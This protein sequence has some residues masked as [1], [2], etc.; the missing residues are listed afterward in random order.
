MSN[1]IKTIIIDDE[2]RGLNVLEHFCSKLSEHIE[3]IASSMNSV[4]SVSLINQLKPEL[5]IM[6]IQ[7]PQMNA[8]DVLNNVSFHDFEVIFCTAHDAYAINAFEFSAVDYLLKPIDEDQ[9]KKAIN[10]VILKR[11]SKDTAERF[12]IL[13]HNISKL[14]NPSSM[15]LCIHD[16]K[17]FSVVFISEILYCEADSSYTVFFLENG[18]KIISSKTLS[19]YESILDT[20]DFIRI[21]RSYLININHVKEYKKGEGG[22]VIMSNKAEI[23]VSRRKKDEFIFRMKNIITS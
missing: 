16:S 5:L 8:F 17:G 11:Q 21:H 22:T 12:S 3:I 19:E 2:P 18:K 4:Q 23:E 6:D 15:K 20:N 1:R 13:I 14:S 9:F 7:M 10:K